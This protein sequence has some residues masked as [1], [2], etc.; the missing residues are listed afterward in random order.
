MGRVSGGLNWCPGI[1]EAN[2]AC[3]L[4]RQFL[5]ALRRRPY[6]TRAY[7]VD[8]IVPDIGCHGLSGVGPT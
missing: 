7:G 2:A 1:L 5:R 8:F 4:L 6:T 3:D